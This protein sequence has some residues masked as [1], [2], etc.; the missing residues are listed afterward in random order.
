[1]EVSGY[2]YMGAEH[3]PIHGHLQADSWDPRGTQQRGPNRNTLWWEL[4]W[5]TLTFVQQVDWWERHRNE[6]KKLRKI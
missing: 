1:M 4:M 5:L 3:F 2:A 6:P